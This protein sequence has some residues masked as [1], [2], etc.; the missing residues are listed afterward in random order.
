MNEDLEPDDS[1]D[2]YGIHDD[3]KL[4]GLIDLQDLDDPQE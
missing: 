1:K 2:G 4:Q 3:L